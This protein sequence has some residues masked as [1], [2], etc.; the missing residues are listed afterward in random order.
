MR[1]SPVRH[2]EISRY[3]RDERESE[4]EDIADPT[5]PQVEAAI[6]RMDNFCFPVVQ[7]NCTDDDGDE[8]IFNVIGGDGRWALFQL[9][10][11]W[12][13][14]DPSRGDGEVRLWESDQG[15]YC[16]ERNVLTDVEKVLRITKEFFDTGS[17]DRLDE[18]A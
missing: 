3:F 15:Y 10:G 6:R 16:L 8:G 4:L 1:A 14:D 12:M 2:L 17:Y 7:L 18:I 9:V 11:D 5:W 13:Y